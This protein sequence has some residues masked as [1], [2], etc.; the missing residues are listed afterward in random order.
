M[1]PIIAVIAAGGRG[2]RFSG[3]Y[4]KQYFKI[5]GRPLLS[6]T[7][8]S[9]L[10]HRLISDVVIV[11]P[12]EDIKDSPQIL[13]GL[14][15]IGHVHF[16]RGG[17]TRTKSVLNGLEFSKSFPQ[18]Y[19]LIHDAVRPF[20]KHSMIER[21]YGALGDNRGIMPVLEV[22]DTSVSVQNGEIINYM[23]RNSL[24]LVQTPQI[25]DKNLL[26]ELMQVAFS[27]NRVFTDESGLLFAYGYK[28]ALARGDILNIKLTS[29]DQIEDFKMLHKLF[30]ED[31]YYMK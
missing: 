21:L 7:I 2:I 11:L 5:R 4:K 6:Y 28:T 25:F 16:T 31:G 12:G 29:Q 26:T 3:D 17:E 15:S 20:F 14:T 13:K 8:Q 22:Y 9:M 19:V 27:E 10:E 18:R 24:R 23:D 30:Y 1:K